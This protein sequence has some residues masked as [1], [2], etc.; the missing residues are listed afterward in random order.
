MKINSISWTGRHLYLS[1]PMGLLLVFVLQIF[2]AGDATAQPFVPVQR[3][4]RETPKRKPLGT[5]GWFGMSYRSG[6]EP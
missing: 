2:A 5:V 1:L 6:T 3:G 4:I